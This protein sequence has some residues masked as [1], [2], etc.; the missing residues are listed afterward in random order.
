MLKHWKKILFG[1]LLA[2][3][4]V[5]GGIEIATPAYE[6]LDEYTEGKVDFSQQHRRWLSDRLVY[7]T[8][9]QQRIGIPDTSLAKAVYAKEEFET[10][11]VRK[12]MVDVKGGQILRDA[13]KGIIAPVLEVVAAIPWVKTAYALTFNIE[14]FESCSVIPCTFTTDSDSGTGA[15]SLDAGSI[16]NGTDSLRCDIAAANDFCMLTKDLTSASTYYFQFYYFVPTGW[17]FGANGYAGLWRSY[18]GAGNPV[19]CLIEDYGVVEITCAGDELGYTDTTL[20]VA[21]NTKTRLEFKVVISTTAGDLDIWLN[22]TTEGTPSYNGSGALNTGSQNITAFQIGG[23][24]PDIVADK[25]YDDTCVDTAFIGTACVAIAASTPATDTS[26]M[27][28][29][30]N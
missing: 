5:L 3:S 8:E 29:L 18:D 16:V 21:L 30:F 1:S 6:S 19:R 28:Q 4:V 15:S 20:S 23:Y 7:M 24:H 11:L 14:D 10:Y 26:S 2:S 17:T 9:N 22:N 12:Q 25:Y 13:P 27:L